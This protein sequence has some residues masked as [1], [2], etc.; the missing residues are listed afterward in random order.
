MSDIDNKRVIELNGFELNLI[1]GLLV[2]EE[3]NVNE[4][5][6]KLIE[7]GGHYNNFKYYVDSLKDLRRRFT[8]MDDT[9]DFCGA[10]ERLETFKLD[11]DQN[12]QEQL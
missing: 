11:A 8:Q 3:N 4:V 5:T 2:N 6:K 12:I 7:E 1:H 9:E 10:F